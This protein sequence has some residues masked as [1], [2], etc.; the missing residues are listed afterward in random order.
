MSK[1]RVAV[2]VR[3]FD[4]YT[5]ISRYVFFCCILKL[6]LKK[7]GDGYWYGLQQRRFYYIKFFCNVETLHVLVKEKSEKLRP[8]Q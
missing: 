7:V 8:S 1:L 2:E 5:R 4:G 3:S 6:V